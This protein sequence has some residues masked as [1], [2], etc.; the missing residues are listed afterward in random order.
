ME[1]EAA[2]AG[3]YEHKLNGQKYP[4]VQLRTVK[5]LME[6]K[7]IE[8]PSSVAA[9]DETFKKAPKAKAKGAEQRGLSL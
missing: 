3:F 6:G 7:A 5:E 8:R 1:V 9:V 2:S 4:R